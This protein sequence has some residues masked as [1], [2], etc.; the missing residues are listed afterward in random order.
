MSLWS[1][2]KRKTKAAWLL[3]FLSMTHTSSLRCVCCCTDFAC[4]ANVSMLPDNLPFTV[5]PLSQSETKIPHL[6]SSFLKSLP[7]RYDAVYQSQEWRRQ[8]IILQGPNQKVVFPTMAA[9]DVSLGRSSE[10]QQDTAAVEVGRGPL[11][12]LKL[13]ILGLH[14]IINYIS[15]QTSI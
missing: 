8:E 12:T 10:D 3:C 15:L 1:K 7:L 14:R 9:A 2:L 13:E 4:T 11:W 6:A 5:A